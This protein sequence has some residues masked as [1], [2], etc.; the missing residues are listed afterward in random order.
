MLLLSIFLST[1]MKIFQKKSD[2]GR[3]NRTNRSKIVNV[4]VGDLDRFLPGRLVR[5]YVIFKLVKFVM[6]LIK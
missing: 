6:F 1:N 2:G 3:R 5:A 4:G